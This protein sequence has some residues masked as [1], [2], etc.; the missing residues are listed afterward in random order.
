[1]K[2]L[3]FAFEGI[4]GCGKSTQMNLLEAAL[5]KLG[6]DTLRIRE[7]GG[8]AAGEEIRNVILKPRQ[9]GLDPLAEVLLYSA[10][11]A[12]LMTQLVQPALDAGKAVL[13]DR[14]AW[15]TMAYQGYGRG[16]NV[17][18]INYLIQLAV[19]QTWP[20]TTFLLD[21]SVEESRRR[22]DNRGEAPDRMEQEKDMFFQKVREG[23]LYIAKTNPDK[24]TCL[25]ALKGIEEIHSQVMAQ[26]KEFL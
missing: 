4:D 8:T 19:G 6:Y 18:D 24:V 20:Q 7:P 16:L 26:V 11:R 3:F 23:Y 25:N 1:M 22:Q 17:D 10:A 14:F 9:E 2:G 15:S 13:A 5:V 12:Q 21:L